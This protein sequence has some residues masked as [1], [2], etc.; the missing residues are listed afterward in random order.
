M[1]VNLDIH[2]VISNNE[3]FQ[4]MKSTRT[5]LTDD[6]IRRICITGIKKCGGQNFKAA[7]KLKLYSMG[8]MTYSKSVTQAIRLIDKTIDDESVMRIGVFMGLSITQTKLRKKI[9]EA[10]KDAEPSAS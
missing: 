1:T 9:D 7:I 2:R 10:I 6:Q 5:N 3:S 4:K 8:V